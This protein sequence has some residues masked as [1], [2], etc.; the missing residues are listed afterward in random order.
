VQTAETATWQTVMLP[1]IPYIY[2]AISTAKWARIKSIP[3]YI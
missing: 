3:D 2:I 1:S